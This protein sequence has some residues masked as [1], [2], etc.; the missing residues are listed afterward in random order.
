MVVSFPRFSSLEELS[1]AVATRRNELRVGL[2]AGT[3]VG[4]VG[5][6]HSED[7]VDIA[8][9]EVQDQ[10]WLGDVHHDG[11]TERIDCSPILRS[12]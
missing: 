4:S 2:R 6:R 11:S 10:S 8:A 7:V 9:I 3:D 5:I 1:P 12:L